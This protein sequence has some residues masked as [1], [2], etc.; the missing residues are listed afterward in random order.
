MFDPKTRTAIVQTIESIKNN[1]LT[2]SADVTTYIVF[3]PPFITGGFFYILYFSEQLC[4]NILESSAIN[5]II[6]Q[7]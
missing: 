7:A 6:S 5:L 2:I 4:Y 1:A 3:S